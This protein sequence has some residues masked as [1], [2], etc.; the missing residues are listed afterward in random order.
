MRLK[1]IFNAF[2]YWVDK[3]NRLMFEEQIKRK[4]KALWLEEAKNKKIDNEMRSKY[5]KVLQ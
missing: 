2:S 3:S 4:D 5:G 1:D